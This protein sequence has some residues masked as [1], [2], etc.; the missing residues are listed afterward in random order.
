MPNDILLQLLIS[1]VKERALVNAMNIAVTELDR[2]VSLEG[3]HT[4]TIEALEKILE[5]S[6]GTQALISTLI[7]DDTEL[8]ETL[9]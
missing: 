8:T 4:L 3:D 9:H 2:I 6:I 5:I 7:D 1:Q